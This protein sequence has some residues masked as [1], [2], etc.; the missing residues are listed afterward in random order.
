MIIIFSAVVSVQRAEQ[1]NVPQQQQVAGAPPMVYPAAPIRYYQSEYMPQ[2]M[3]ILVL[4]IIFY[5]VFF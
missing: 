2:R 3:N 5:M 1:S 4:L